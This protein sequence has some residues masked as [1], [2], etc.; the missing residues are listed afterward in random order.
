ME[1][2]KRQAS[3]TAVDVPHAKLI[4]EEIPTTTLPQLSQQYASTHAPLK[5]RIRLGPHPSVIPPDAPTPN[6]DT[7]RLV[8]SIGGEEVQQLGAGDSSDTHIET[9]P[10]EDE[11][12]SDDVDDIYEGETNRAF[13]NVLFDKEFKAHSPKKNLKK[14]WEY[15]IPRIASVLRELIQEHHALKFWVSLLVEYTKPNAPVNPDKP[16]EFYLHSGSFTVL[17][18]NNIGELLE[19]VRTQIELR[20][21]H[22]IREQSGLVISRI[23]SLR[24]HVGKFS[25]LSA[26]AYLKVPKELEKKKAIVNVKNTD[27]RCFGYAILSKL[28]YNEITPHNQSIP[29]SYSKYFA[30]NVHNLNSLSYPV[31]PDQ[32]PAIEDLLKININVITFYDENGTD[33]CPIYISRKSHH[34]DIDLL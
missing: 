26:G 17:N 13:Q 1:D 21:A 9:I 4:R 27:N 10:K 33:K 19:S 15:S 23:I 7:N 8:K 11:T 22:F 31:S 34:E 6:P 3:P 2:R 14:F 28:F 5:V 24:L 29:S 12:S 30:R 20:N 18:N 32:I 25:P 16:S